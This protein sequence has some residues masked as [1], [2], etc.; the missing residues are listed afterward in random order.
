[1][2]IS[3]VDVESYSVSVSYL[4]VDFT[5]F[6]LPARLNASTTVRVAL[7]GVPDPVPSGVILKIDSLSTSKR[8]PLYKTRSSTRASALIENKIVPRQANARA[9]SRLFMNVREES[10]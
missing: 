3:V 4:I 5:A 7:S 8:L 1:M 10:T 9:T 6:G 2:T